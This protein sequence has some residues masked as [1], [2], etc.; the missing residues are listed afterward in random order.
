MPIDVTVIAP[1]GQSGSIVNWTDPTATDNSD[2]NV[3]VTSDHNSGSEIKIG[4]TTV[5]YT[6]VDS[7]GNEA[8]ESFKITVKGI[9]DYYTFT[10]TDRW[11]GSYFF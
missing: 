2:E 3:K 11:H 9:S 7:Y 8:T 4:V 6:A 5:T 10:G 1:P